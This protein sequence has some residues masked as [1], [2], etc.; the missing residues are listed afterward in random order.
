M[1]PMRLKVIYILQKTDLMRMQMQMKC[2]VKARLSILY[3]P[4]AVLIICCVIGM[5][6]TGGFFSGV[7]FISAFSGS[8]ASLGLMLGSF[9]AL[10]II[11]IF[12][13]IRKVLKFT[14]CCKC[15][16]DGF[17]AMVPAILILTFAWT[18]K[19]MTDSLGAKEYV[20]DLV[21]NVSGMWLNLLPAIVFIIGVFLAFCYGNIMGNIR[22]TYP[23]SCRC[24]FNNQPH[25]DDHCDFSMYGRCGMRRSLFADIGYY[26]NGFCRCAVQSYEP[27][28]HP[29]AVCDNG[30]NSIM[31]DI[32][33]CRICQESGR[34]AC[35]RNHIDDGHDY[36][37]QIP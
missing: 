37:N 18:L 4:V 9:A 35:Y 20:A 31:R 28:I 1:K 27:C 10:I 34:I 7:D 15:V 33:N 36:G 29:V 22:N 21:R 13:S 8:N 5:I 14:D 30:C 24:I 26:N 17:K 6:Y 32:Y 16:P 19:S 2:M 11:I 12:Y 23:D 25:D 3:S